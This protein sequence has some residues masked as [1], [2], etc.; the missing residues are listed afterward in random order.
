MGRGDIQ[1]EL[2]SQSKAD[3]MTDY[4]QRKHTKRVGKSVQSWHVNSLWA[5]KRE[6]GRQ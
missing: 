6:L 5:E 2:E 3:T 4:R 1:K